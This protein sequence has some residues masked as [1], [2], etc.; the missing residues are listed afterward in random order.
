[1]LTADL[2]RYRVKAGQLTLPGIPKKR[3]ADMRAAAELLLNSARQG[4]GASRQEL[5][6][7]FAEIEPKATADRRI[8]DGFQKLILD[9]CDFEIPP[10]LNPPVLRQALFQRASELR[11]SGATFDRWAILKEVGT[12]FNLEPG[13]LEAALYADLKKNQLLQSFETISTEGLLKL[14]DLS[15]AQA[16][17]LKAVHLRIFIRCQ[18]AGAYRALFHKL[19]FH[20]LLYNIHPQGAGYRLEI[21]GPHSLFKQVTKYGLQLAL[22]LPSIRS[23]TEWSLRAQV[24]WGKQRKR[25][26]FELSGGG[27]E[28][29][30]ELRLPDEV[31]QLR[32]RFATRSSPWSVHISTKIFNLPALGVC[33][34]DLRFRHEESSLDVYLEVMGYWSRE[35]VWKRV[36]LVRAGLPEP[37]IFAVSSRLRVSEAVL[38][39]EAMATLYVY[40]GSLIPKGVEERLNAFLKEKGIA[41]DSTT[42]FKNEP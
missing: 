31:E 25:L 24:L 38:E 23:C 22:L 19:K 8:L 32:A 21:S 28:E 40:K 5:L 9:R 12:S 3:Q 17:L 39:D 6:E 20:R 10:E 35:A 11:L 36:D 29:P 27:E 1:V 41:D 2:V 37:L 33:V 7:A 16:V 30:P 42:L 4:L 15:Q 26:S 14:Y 18:E 34:P 13:Q